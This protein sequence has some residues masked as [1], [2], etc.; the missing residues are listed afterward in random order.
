MVVGGEG[1]SA[2]DQISKKGGLDRISVFRENCLKR[3]GDIFKE[4]GV[5]GAVST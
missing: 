3:V 5:V 4:G 1:L 2:S